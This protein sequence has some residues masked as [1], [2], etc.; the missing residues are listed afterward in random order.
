MPPHYHDT[1][2]IPG[3]TA[4]NMGVKNTAL[5]SIARV[6]TART[7]EILF[8]DRG[9]KLVAEA[10]SKLSNDLK[11]EGV[12]TKDIYLLDEMMDNIFDVWAERR[13][14][15]YRENITGETNEES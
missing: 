4:Q 2:I 8:S 15:I 7:I 13:M 6:S 3:Q 10:L 12:R 1:E 11:T 14:D 5:T 9:R